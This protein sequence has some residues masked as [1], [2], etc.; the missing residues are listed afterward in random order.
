MMSRSVLWRWAE[1]E[2]GRRIKLGTAERK[3][4]EIGWGKLQL[5]E[6]NKL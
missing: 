5:K 1:K 2:E 6:G 4:G 3:V